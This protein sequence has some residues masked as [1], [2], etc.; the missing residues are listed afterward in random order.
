MNEYKFF[1]QNKNF[2]YT[3]VLTSKLNFSKLCKYFLKN[4][5]WRF[6]TGLCDKTDILDLGN[7][8]KPRRHNDLGQNL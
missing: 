7:T 1:P 2:F 3:S 8:F 6:L 4:I 5:D